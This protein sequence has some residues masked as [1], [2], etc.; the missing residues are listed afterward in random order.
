MMSN[1]AYFLVGRLKQH[2]AQRHVLVFLRDDLSQ[3]SVDVIPTPRNSWTES[4]RNNGIVWMK[5]R[6][7]ANTDNMV[8]QTS[9]SRIHWRP[10][11]CLA[12]PYEDLPMWKRVHDVTIVAFVYKK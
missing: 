5:E 1:S 6:M 4:G 12:Q 8:G 2:A 9:G 11:E 3:L 7:I 10:W